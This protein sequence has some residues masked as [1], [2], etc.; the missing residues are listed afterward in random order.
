M[1]SKS[2]KADQLFNKSIK[3]WLLLGTLKKK[4][5]KLTKYITVF[6]N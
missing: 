4:N 2:L 1:K 5:R 6:E 3:R